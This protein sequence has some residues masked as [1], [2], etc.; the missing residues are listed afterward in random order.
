M[1]KMSVRPSEAGLGNEHFLNILLGNECFLNILLDIKLSAFHCGAK[2]STF[3]LWRQIVM[4]PDC[5]LLQYSAK[6]SVKLGGAKLEEKLNF[7]D[8]LYQKYDT[9]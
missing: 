2:L 9:V 3:T 8:H 6:L 1:Q 5:P 7:I 4:V